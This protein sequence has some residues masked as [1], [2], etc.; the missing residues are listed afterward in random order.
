MLV[1]QLQP[2]MLDGLAVVRVAA[3]SMAM[4]T[5]NPL[6]VAPTSAMTSATNYCSGTVPTTSMIGSSS[7]GCASW[8][9]C[10]IAIAPAIWKA[11]TL[12]G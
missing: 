4:V 10:R 11:S 2:V 7:T 9:A 12:H 3:T 8:V 6:P 5:I 1:N